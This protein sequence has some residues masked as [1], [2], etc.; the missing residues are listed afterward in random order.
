MLFAVEDVDEVALESVRRAG[1]TYCDGGWFI[2]FA[3]CGGDVRRGSSVGSMVDDAV[4]FLEWL[5][6]LPSSG[7]AG[8]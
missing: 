2:G 7:C 1:W 5:D 8:G 4:R 3:G 6:C